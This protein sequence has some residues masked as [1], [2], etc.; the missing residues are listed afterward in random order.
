VATVT[1]INSAK[2][3]EQ[4]IEQVAAMLRAGI[5]NNVVTAVKKV[6]PHKAAALADMMAEMQKDLRR[7]E[8]A[9]RVAAVQQ[10]LAA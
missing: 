3:F 5:D 8:T 10:E 7:I 1:E 2:S 9:L 6:N 4:R